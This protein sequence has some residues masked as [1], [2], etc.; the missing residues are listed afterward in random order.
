[1][2]PKGR[3][4]R[5]VGAGERRTPVFFNV[6]DDKVGAG[7]VINAGRPFGIIHGVGHVAHQGDMFAEFD[8]LTNGEWSSQNAHVQVNPAEDD[9]VDAPF[10][11]QVPGLLSI[12]GEGVARSQFDGGDSNIESASSPTRRDGVHNTTFRR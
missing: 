10:G 3:P 5:D 4:G 6:L 1:M 9:V 8:H 2:K 12:I 7:E 11:K